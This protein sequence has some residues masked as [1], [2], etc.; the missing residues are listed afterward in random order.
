MMQIIFD[1]RDNSFH[2]S[3]ET[4]EAISNPDEISFLLNQ[5]KKQFLIWRG[6][7]MVDSLGKHRRKPQTIS[8]CVL[9]KNTEQT[10]DG[11]CIRDCGTALKALSAFIPGFRGGT[12]YAFDGQLVMDRAVAFD[13]TKAEVIVKGAAPAD[14]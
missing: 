3:R 5:E 12:A 14:S 1:Y 8:S 4:I 9:S 7:V 10:A 2:I 13:L 6:G 11:F